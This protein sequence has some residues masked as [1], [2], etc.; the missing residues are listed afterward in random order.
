VKQGE[1]IP[2]AAKSTKLTN[3]ASKSG[4]HQDA[5]DL[6]AG[7]CFKAY[8]FASEQT[9]LQGRLGLL[10]KP[11]FR[12]IFAVTELCGNANL[13]S[14]AFRVAQAIACEPFVDVMPE[15]DYLC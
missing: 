4:R 6:E 1:V 14:A 8:P 5:A 15:R 13:Q 11:C 12:K 9:A 7:E 3:I 10:F 2:F